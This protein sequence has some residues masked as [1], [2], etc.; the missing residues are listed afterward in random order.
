MAWSPLLFLLGILLP[1]SLAQLPAW[2]GLLLAAL[3]LACV[4]RLA[5][6]LPLALGV[7]WTSLQ[8]SQELARQWPCSADRADVEL[9][10]RVLSTALQREGRV[11]FELR[12]DAGPAPLANGGRVYL[13]WYDATRIP[14]PGESLRLEV[15]LRCPSGLRNPSGH[16][17]ELSL[18]RQGIHATGWLRS[19]PRL[20][21]HVA[22][23][24]S[25]A[26]ESSR[27]RVGAAIE[28]ATGGGD[29]AAVLQGLS[30]GLRAGMSADLWE[31]FANTGLAHLIAISGSH[32]TAFAV[33]VLLL[34]RVA[35]RLLAPPGGNRRI[36]IEA[37]LLFLATLGYA[38]L[39]G[40]STP[41]LRTAA[42]V[43][44]FLILRLQRRHLS[45]SVVLIIAAALLG[46]VTPLATSSAGFW[47]SFVATAA[48]VTVM[49]ART[50]GWGRLRKFAAS[51]IAVLLALAPVLLLSFGRV[52]LAAPLANA[53]ALPLFTLL[54]LPITLA[55]TA[56]ELAGIGL[57]A[58]GWHWLGKMLDPLWQPLIELGRWHYSSWAVARTVTPALLLAT[59][60]I[61]AGLLLPVA[62][63]RAALLVGLASLLMARA[64][65]PAAG[66]LELTVVDVGQGLSVIVRTRA[67]VLL[68]DTGPGWRGGGSAAQSALL[69]LLERQGIRRIDR[70]V[71]SHPDQ[72]HTGGA[73]YLQ[74]RL[75]IKEVMAPAGKGDAAAS[76]PCVLGQSWSW[77]GVHFRVLHPPAAADWSDNDRSCALMIE[78][79]GQRV[80]LLA[81][82][83]WLAEQVM[84]RQDLSADI[85]LVP[86][87]GSRSSSGA[88]LVQLVDARL[89]VV[90]TGFG[91]RW[92]LPSTEVVARW[93]SHGTTI[94]ETGRAGA[95]QL[96]IAPGC[97]L[98]NVHVERIHAPR[99]W[100]RERG[101]AIGSG[102]V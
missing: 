24:W 102:T 87:H 18:L 8:A 69:P 101:A 67:H 85:V 13:S 64:P 89:G 25:T 62:G 31:A 60:A 51:Q 27:S 7:A 1:W 43:S 98:C 96:Q 39:A 93:R 80:L 28:A 14:Q 76:M 35:W 40:Y 30:V 38:L 4:R 61:A 92:G 95:V 63:L 72:D 6:L 23:D 90:S 73:R 15:R 16:D 26:L 34:L 48:L 11:E 9:E 42:T 74:E 99:W 55:L 88:E 97:G 49:V 3:G 56:L 45:M 58:P 37:T 68:Y 2:P 33:W 94:L 84:L 46:L 12:V 54:L 59:V 19:P 22:A 50:G 91:N 77:D 79:G 41:T 52:S 70:M 29:S 57:A 81:D 36:A 20:L 17:R 78:A 21:P 66:G 53:L 5:W 44:L 83:E 86:H 71:L 65:L 47:L 10:G 75:E 32:V 82:P 100:S